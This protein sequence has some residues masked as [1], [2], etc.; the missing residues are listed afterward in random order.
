MRSAHTVQEQKLIQS[1]IDRV[2]AVQREID[3]LNSD[4]AVI[5]AEAKARDLDVKALKNVIKC[6]AKDANLMDREA[7][8][9]AFEMYWHSAHA[10]RTHVRE[11]A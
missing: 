8:L 2:E 4:K 1:I 9:E 5:F 11:V 3:S 6:R 10:S 7:D